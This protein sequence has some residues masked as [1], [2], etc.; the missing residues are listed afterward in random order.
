M[1][2]QHREQRFESVDSVE[3]FERCGMTEGPVF[4]S[5][6]HLCSVCKKGVGRNSVYCSFCKHWVHK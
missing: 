4:A 2:K 1:E 6:K 5:C 3:R